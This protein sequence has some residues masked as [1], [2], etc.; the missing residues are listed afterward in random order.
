MDEGSLFKFGN[1]DQ[2]TDA[3]KNKNPKEPC[4]NV[5]PKDFKFY[6]EN[7]LLA[8]AGTRD[9]V[10]WE[11]ITN[12]PLTASFEQ[13]Q[14]GMRVAED[15]DYRELFDNEDIEQGYG[16]LY[17]DDATETADHIRDVYGY[18]YNNATMGRGMRGCFVYNKNTGKNLFFPIGASSYREGRKETDNK[19][20]I[21]RYG[22]RT[23]YFPSPSVNDRHLFYD[24][25]KRPGALYWYATHVQH[26]DNTFSIGWD[27]NYF[28][29]DFN[30]ILESNVFKNGKSDALFVH[31]VVAE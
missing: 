29:F 24:L 6:P 3:L 14:P 20:G 26:S 25:F 10:S 15:K 7:G 22:N 9:N 11:N 27:I 13:P 16:V 19:N 23:E 30:N 5:G 28:T 17:G 2:P 12:L 21:L 8:I 18:D 1:W 31:C 4:I